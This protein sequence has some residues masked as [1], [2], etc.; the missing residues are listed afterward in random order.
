MPVLADHVSFR[1]GSPLPVVGND[2]LVAEDEALSGEI[3]VTLAGDCTLGGTEKAGSRAHGFTQTVLREGLDY[4]FSGLLPLFSSDDLTWV[5]LEGVLSDSPAGEDRDKAFAFRGPASFARILPLGGVEAVNVANNHSGD[6]G[7]R[8]R[9]ATLAALTAE[10]VAFSGNEWLCVYQSRGF[11]IGLAGLSGMLTDEK[12]NAIRNQ[13][14]LLRKS[15]CEVVLFSMHTGIENQPWHTTAQRETARFLI[16]AGADLVA[17]HHPH[18][19]QGIEVYKDRY[20]FYSLGNCA[21]GG[22]HAP[23]STGALAARVVFTLRGGRLESLRGE[24]FPMRYTG[25]L[26]GNAFRPV[27]LSGEEAEAV[28]DRVRRDTA[29]PIPSLPEEGGAPLPQISCLQDDGD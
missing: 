4:P 20:I 13:V 1:D 22:N 21:F 19:P 15:G 24:L 7:A 9:A 23:S 29:F 12:R 6:Y 8:G 26:R 5:N 25:T 11:R 3:A 27:L 2:F 17:G 28:L 14:S 18:V 10:K 16:D